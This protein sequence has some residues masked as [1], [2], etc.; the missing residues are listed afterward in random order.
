VGGVGGVG[1]VDDKRGRHIYGVDWVIGVDWCGLVW[2]GVDWCGLA[3]IGVD[4]RGLARI[5]ALC[6][7]WCDLACLAYFVW[8][9][10]ISITHFI[11]NKMGLIIVCWCGIAHWVVCECVCVCECV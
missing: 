2:I 6:V 11:P 8:I 10:E 4:W 7:D 1:G 9:G 5:G 3:W